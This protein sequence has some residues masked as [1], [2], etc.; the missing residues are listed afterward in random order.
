MR[1]AFDAKRYFHN[2][3]GL[4]NYSRTLVR[5]LQQFFPEDDH[6][7]YDEKAIKRTLNLGMQAA[8]DSCDIYHGLSN[9]LPF[10][11]HW[12]DTGHPRA[13]GLHTPASVITMHDVCWRT[14]PEMYHWHDRKLYDWKY[15]SSC[16]RADKI[17]AISE[18]TKRDIIDIYDIPEDRIEVIYQ[19]VGEEFYTKP[20]TPPADRDGILYVGSINQRKNLLCLLQAL[21]IIPK[22]NR[23]KLT[24]VGNGKEYRQRCEAFIAEHDLG[25]YVEIKGY[26]NSQEELLSL[27]ATAKAFVFPSF[28]EGFGLPIVEAALQHTPVIT[29]TASSLPEAAGPDACFIDPN[30]V[31]AAE[32]LA[33][34]IDRL[35]SDTEFAETVADKCEAYA[36]RVFTPETLTKQ[37]HTLYESLI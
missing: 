20:S 28:Y 7:L 14:F 12:R 11:L 34:H 15:G 5:G 1:I 17:I 22:D 2:N 30:A 16:R 13:A 9:E 21:E 32:Q 18:S 4:G 37:V 19:P 29:S 3:T 26:V 27:Y 33:H 36:R 6:I 35:C 31:D 23:P 24:V 10:D 25:N 8:K